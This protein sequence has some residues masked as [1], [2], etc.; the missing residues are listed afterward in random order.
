[1]IE[2]FKIVTERDKLKMEDFFNAVKYLQPPW[3]PVQ[4]DSPEESHKYPVKFFQ[5]ARR[6]YLEQSSKYCGF[7][8]FGKQLQES[9]GWLCRVGYIKASAY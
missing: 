5:S 8:K 9:Y 7:C 3:S 1:L 4:D 6:E 2:T